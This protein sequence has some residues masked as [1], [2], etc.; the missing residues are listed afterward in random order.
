[1]AYC[2]SINLFNSFSVVVA[3][4]TAVGPSSSDRGHSRDLARVV[5]NKEEETRA[6]LRVVFLGKTIG[7]ED[8]ADISLGIVSETSAAESFPVGVRKISLV[9][10]SKNAFCLSG[11]NTPGGDVM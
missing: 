2:S 7:L 10:E 11:G 3:H 4:S 1:M 8:Q 6:L 9:I 5:G